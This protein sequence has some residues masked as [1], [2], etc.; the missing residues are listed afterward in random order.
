MRAPALEHRPDARVTERR[1]GRGPDDAVG[2]QSARALE[3]LHGRLRRR[4][5]DAVG[6]DPERALQSPHGAAA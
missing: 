5:E 1:P 4:P 2:G 3:A 6:S